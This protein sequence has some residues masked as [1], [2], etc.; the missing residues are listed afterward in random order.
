MDLN[1]PSEIIGMVTTD[2][3]N[4]S[5]PDVLVP[6]IFDQQQKM[7]D[8]VILLN[9]GKGGLIKG[10]SQVFADGTPTVV[11]ATEI[12]IMADFNGDERD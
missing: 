8:L 1:L 7:A 10:N 11:N 5:L 3:N 12:S 9:N 4:D 6:T 2:F